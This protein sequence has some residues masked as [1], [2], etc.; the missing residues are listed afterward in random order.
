MNLRLNI[1]DDQI[2]S[3]ISRSLN[4]N[5]LADPLHDLGHN[6]NSSWLKASGP[7]RS[8]V[9]PVNSPPHYVAWKTLWHKVRCGE[10]E[11]PKKPS[12]C[13]R[14]LNPNRLDERRTLYL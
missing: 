13:D 6:A 1:L 9:V 3:N 10:V 5:R 7:P 4:S 12:C 8:T 14:G 11:K 2:R